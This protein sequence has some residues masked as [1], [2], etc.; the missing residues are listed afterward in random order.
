MSSQ[1]VRVFCSVAMSLAIFVWVCERV[2]DRDAH[3][4][5]V[6]DVAGDHGQ[7]VFEGCRGDEQ[8]G[9]VMSE[10]GGKGGPSVAP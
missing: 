6:T 9:A 7:A 2:E 1:S 4:M 5:E 3:R 10:V 8:V